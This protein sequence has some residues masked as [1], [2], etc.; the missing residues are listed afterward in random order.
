M[1]GAL[2]RIVQIEGMAK[3]ERERERFIQG[4]K[5]YGAC[6]SMPNETVISMTS[7][8][9][10]KLH[11]RNSFRTTPPWPRTIGSH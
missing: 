2:L 8:E 10:I 3:L 6:R 1:Y 7:Y 5:R 11:D 4:L 9:M